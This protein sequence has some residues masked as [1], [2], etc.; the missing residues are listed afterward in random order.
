M[1]IVYDMLYLFYFSYMN[2]LERLGDPEYIP[3]E[4]DVLRTRVKTT[5]IVETEFEY[6]H[7]K[8]LWVLLCEWVCVCTCIYVFE[9]CSTIL[10]MY[11]YMYIFIPCNSRFSWFIFGNYWKSFEFYFYLK[12]FVWSLLKYQK[13][14]KY[15][16][17]KFRA[18]WWLKVVWKLGMQDLISDIMTLL[19]WLVLNMF[20][21]DQIHISLRQVALTIQYV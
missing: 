11:M 10:Y 14:L 8:F 6:K 13:S 19:V 9:Y 3:S 20:P 2:A 7:L 5:G 12:N 1:C 4:Q 15:C 17:K 16:A 18:I 21:Y